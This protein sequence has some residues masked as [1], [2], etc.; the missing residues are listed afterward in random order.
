MHA[1]RTDRQTSL[2]DGPSS[3]ALCSLPD[4]RSALT[5]EAIAFILG[6][7]IVQTHST[8]VSGICSCLWH[9]LQLP[10]KSK[11]QVAKGRPD[12]RPTPPQD[13]QPF[14]VLSQLARE[15]PFVHAQLSLC[16]VPSTQCCR[17][18]VVM[19]PGLAGGGRQGRST[20]TSPTGRSRSTIPCHHCP[21]L[22]LSNCKTWKNPR[23]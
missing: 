4:R 14:V 23:A 12:L 7:E 20:A 9:R 17:G 2:L 13:N 16:T 22:F 5:V 18:A 21:T 1:L 10:A 19:P 3:C 8:P 11:M 6:Q 15:A